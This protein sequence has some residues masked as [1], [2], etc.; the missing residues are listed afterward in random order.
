MLLQVTRNG[1]GGCEKMFL[2][3]R[4]ATHPSNTSNQGHHHREGGKR[5]R[6]STEG[7]GR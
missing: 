3:L 1:K 5:T 2:P 6:K 4:A 7:H